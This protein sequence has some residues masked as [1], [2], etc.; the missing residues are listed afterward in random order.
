MKQVTDPNLLAILN[1][2]ES[3]ASTGALPQVTDP[4]L[5]AQLNAT[6]P[7]EIIQDEINPPKESANLLKWA[8]GGAE[9]VAGMLAQIPVDAVSGVAGLGSMALGGDGANTV[10][11]VQNA[12][13]EFLPPY[14][15]EGKVMQE[16]VG[17]TLGPVVEWIDDQTAGRVAEAGYPMLCHGSPHG[18]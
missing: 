5:L 11:T 8:L 18:S 6:E 2:G 9:N 14:T 1:S 10:K 17:E 3:T 15:N 4:E 13:G 16:K 7:T 12:L